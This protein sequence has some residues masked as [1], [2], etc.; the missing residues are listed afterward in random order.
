MWL[1]ACILYT[2]Y[3]SLLGDMVHTAEPNKSLKLGRVFSKFITY[4]P[5]NYYY[6]W[7]CSNR[8]VT[9]IFYLSKT[10]LPG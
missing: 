10:K 3:T 9:Q 6:K 1:S 7:H 2:N 5:H 8:N 4:T